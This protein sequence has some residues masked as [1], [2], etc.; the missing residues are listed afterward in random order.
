MI[1]EL[2]TV[3]ETM[4]NT[5]YIDN[6]PLMH[7]SLIIN[8]LQNVDNMWITLNKMLGY[9]LRFWVLIPVGYTSKYIKC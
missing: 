4:E 9:I 7:N 5:Q 8:Q 3:Q 1:I 2:Y 6:Q